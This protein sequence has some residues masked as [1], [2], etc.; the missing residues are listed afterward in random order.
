MRGNT[1]NI[2]FTGLLYLCLAGCLFSCRKDES[3]LRGEGDH[4]GGGD[5]GEINDSGEIKGFFLLNEGNMG[6]NKATLDYYDYESGVY[7]R[8]I[9]PERNPGVA[10]E[11]GDVGNDLGVYGGKLYAVINCSNLV[12]V[13][14]AETAV[15]V[16]EIP[17]PNCRYIVF[18]GGYAYVSSYA[19]AVEFD[20]EYRRGYVAKIDTVDYDSTVSVIDL[21]TFEI[22]N[23]IEV[24]PNLHQMKLGGDGMLYVS[25]RGDY[26][27]LQSSTYIIDPS[28][29]EVVE[30]LE[31]LQNSDMAVYG[32]Y[33]YVI[34][35]SWSNVSLDYQTGYTVFDTR[36]RVTE[37]RNFITDGT[38]DEITTPYCIAVNPVNGDMMPRIMSLRAIYTV[39]GRT[40]SG[41][42]LRGQVIYPLI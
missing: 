21:A 39:T 25:S 23:E 4:V 41:N 18:D 15:H 36:D 37:T 3:V 27:G 12:E 42:G 34:A 6:S 28:T 7:T 20:P 35:H 26:Y 8:N 1:A 40:V 16:A 11:L 30:E 22:V 14:D 24:A 17:L 19:G 31:L 33:L 38:E 5:S 13:M 29:D 2:I 32:D 9:Y 10:L